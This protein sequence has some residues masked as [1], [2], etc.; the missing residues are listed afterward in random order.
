MKFERHEY[1]RVCKSH[2]INLNKSIQ[3]HVRVGLKIIDFILCYIS[4]N[5]KIRNQD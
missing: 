1:T 3:E 2:L 5:V 4:Q